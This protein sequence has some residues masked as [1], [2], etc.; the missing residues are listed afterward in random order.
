[1]P[2]VNTAERLVSA[3]AQLLDTG[4]ETAVTLRSVAAAVG[5]SHNAPYKHFASRDAL[6][7]GVAAADLTALTDVWEQ[8]RT[9]PEEPI[10]RLLGALDVV[11]CYSQAHPARY[12][13][14]FG[15]PDI[16]AVGGPLTVAGN[17]AMGVFAAIV[18]DCQTAGAL[19]ASPG[20]KL[21]IILFAAMHGLVNADSDRLR[22]ESGWTDIRSGMEFLIGLLG[23]PTK[24]PTGDVGGF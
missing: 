6:L 13:L 18:E 12:R 20:N 4:G 3:A 14:L 8:I 2:A 19:P 11:I 23:A 22:S 17:R 16:A 5:V 21:A 9:A 24:N 1:M 7:A 15:S 10:A